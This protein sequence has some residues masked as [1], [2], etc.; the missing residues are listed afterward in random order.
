MLVMPDLEEPFVPLGSDGLF[1]D[2]Y[3]SKLVFACPF[4]DSKANE[5]QVRHNVSPPTTTCTFLRGPKS[6]ARIIA[7]PGLCTHGPLY[8]WGQDH[9]LPVCVTY[10]GPR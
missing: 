4:L 6:R 2:P 3:E 1:V 10:L 9:M 8:D 7:N 5:L